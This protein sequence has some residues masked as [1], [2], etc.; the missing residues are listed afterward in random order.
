MLRGM[1]TAFSLIAIR[2]IMSVR[3][4]ITFLQIL[5]FCI[6]QDR[7]TVLALIFISLDLNEFIRFNLS[8]MID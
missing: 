1:D 7:L 2:R 3:T 4:S 6:L 8:W 5:N